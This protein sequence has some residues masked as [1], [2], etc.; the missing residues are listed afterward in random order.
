MRFHAVPE[1]WC[2][3]FNVAW[4]QQWHAGVLHWREQGQL[5][6][7]TFQKV[8]LAPGALVP[9]VC[10]QY[11]IDHSCDLPL[12]SSLM[13]AICMICSF[14]TAAV[15]AGS[16]SESEPQ[17]MKQVCRFAQMSHH[18]GSAAWIWFTMIPYDV[19]WTD[20]LDFPDFT[21]PN[22]PNS[23]VKS[24]NCRC[25]RRHLQVHSSEPA[26]EIKIEGER[27]DHV[28]DADE[29]HRMQPSGWY[30]SKGAVLR[31]DRKL[32]AEYV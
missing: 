28:P 9:W 11:S 20:F 14:C 22:W 24:V 29:E 6:G 26:K 8:L 5:S 7:S 16:L 21:L 31:S 27:I 13:L 10:F 15:K 23:P 2:L 30:N 32:D 17:L 19:S 25:P 12:L 1:I 4:G 3:T 18:R